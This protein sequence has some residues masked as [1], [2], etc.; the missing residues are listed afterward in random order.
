MYV[1]TIQDLEFSK[2]QGEEYTG[3]LGERKWK[4]EIMQL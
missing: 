2:E 1:T 4:G 3:E